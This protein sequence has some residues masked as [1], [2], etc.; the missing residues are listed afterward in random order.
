MEELTKYEIEEFREVI[1]LTT[2]SLSALKSPYQK[3]RRDFTVLRYSI[4]F[5]ILINYSSYRY[6]Q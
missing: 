3:G 5:D 4:E 6:F 1:S 2:S